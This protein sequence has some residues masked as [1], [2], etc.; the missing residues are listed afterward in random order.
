MVSELLSTTEGSGGTT[1]S[2]LY[3]YTDK[4]NELFP[5]YL[6]IGMTEEQYWD[7]DCTL[8]IP[9]RKADELKNNRK[10]QE[11][12]LQGAYI[13]DALSRVS[14]LLHAFAKKGTK[15]MP[16]L[17]EPYTFDEKQT[18]LKEIEKDKTIFDKAKNLMEG[19]M[20]QNNKKFER[21]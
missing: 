4:F 10:N 15:P 12:W 13:Y 11:M 3:T 8:V 1:T 2:P 7:K 6:S 21:K 16:Y 19:F 18:E 5:Y 20:V 9:Y 14:P 17:S